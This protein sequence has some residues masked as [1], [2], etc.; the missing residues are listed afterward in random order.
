MRL[1]LGFPW[2]IRS[3]FK[4]LQLRIMEKMKPMKVESNLSK[5]V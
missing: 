2:E 5:D 4:M 3:N 1:A